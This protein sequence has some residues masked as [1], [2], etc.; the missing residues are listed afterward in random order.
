MIQSILFDV[1]DTLLDFEPLNMKC[2]VEQGARDSYQRLLESGLRLPPLARYRR[3]HLWAVRLGLIWSRLRRRE[4]DML[5]ILRRL[6]LRA[7][8]PHSDA[9]ILDLAWRWYRPVVEY[10]RI[11]P[12]L[13]ATLQ[14]FQTAGIKMGLVS[15]TCIGKPILDRHLKEMGLLDYFP[16]RVYSSEVGYRKPHPRIFKR[17][18]LELDANPQSTLFVGDLLKNDILGARKLGMKTALKQRMS[19]AHTHPIADHVIRRIS[20]LSPIVLPPAELRRRHG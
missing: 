20:D 9:L 10:S 17:A 5:K 6:A 19:M 16:V 7:G 3:H 15:N 13:V 18:L 14:L 12:D 8:A 4:M 2:V 11:E 1:G